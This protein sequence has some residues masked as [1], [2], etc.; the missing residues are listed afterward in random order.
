MKI[1]SIDSMNLGHVYRA[2]Y[3]IRP[4]EP[5]QCQEFY[6]LPGG[7]KGLNQFVALTKAGVDVFHIGKV[8]HDGLCFIDLMKEAGFH[9]ELS[10]TETAVIQVND[11]R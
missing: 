4:D 3:F 1:L 6:I 11:S 10:E 7:R 2:D 8:K 5:Q 9:T